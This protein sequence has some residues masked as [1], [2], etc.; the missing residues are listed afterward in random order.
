MTPD[1]TFRLHKI[2]EWEIAEKKERESKGKEATNPEREGRGSNTDRSDNE[3]SSRRL[4][5]QGQD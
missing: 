5:L 1:E 3:L 2:R 4:S